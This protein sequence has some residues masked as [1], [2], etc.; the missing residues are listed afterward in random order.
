MH[1][2]LKLLSIYL[3]F[4]A[5]IFTGCDP[6]ADPLPEETDGECPAGQNVYTAGFEEIQGNSVARFWKNGEMQNLAGSSDNTLRSTGTVNTMARSVYVSGDDVYVAGYTVTISGDNWYFDGNEIVTNG[7]EETAQARLWKN[8]EIQPLESGT[9]SDEALSVFVSGSDVYVLGSESLYPVSFRMGR[10][11][12]KYWKNGKAEI[13]AEGFA[14]DGVKSIFVS[15]GNIYV[16]GGYGNQAKLWKNGLEE[17]LVGGTGAN[18]VLVSAGNVY[19]A[20]AGSSGAILWKNGKAENLT[21]GTNAFSVYVSG[22]DVYV[23]GSDGSSSKAR[24]WKNGIIQ[25]V[26]DDD[27]AIMFLSVFVKENDVYLS[28]YVQAIEPIQGSPLSIGYLKATLW[29]NGKILNLKTEGKNNSRALSVF[30]K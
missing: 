5:L 27:D 24:L 3:L 1:S 30:V 29:K 22:N 11:A 26:A 28:G 18:S 10:W 12:Y 21:N 25:E 8:G 6:K 2:K 13:F 7:D 23:A 16:A 17:N 9:Y 4:A 14:R 19:V 15:D 20:G